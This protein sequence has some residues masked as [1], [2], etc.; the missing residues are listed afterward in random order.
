[1][2]RY[3]YAIV[4]FGGGVSEPCSSMAGRMAL[5]FLVFFGQEKDTQSL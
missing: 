1:V 5:G 2:Y 3:C 4:V